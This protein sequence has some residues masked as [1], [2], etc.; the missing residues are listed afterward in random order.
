MQM[1]F[2]SS[3]LGAY[4]SKSLYQLMLEMVGEGKD[5]D[6][7]G[8]QYHKDQFDQ[9]KKKVSEMQSECQKIHDKVSQSEN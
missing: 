2:N 4:S 3:N 5:K 1:K 7:L 8:T 6:L 9:I